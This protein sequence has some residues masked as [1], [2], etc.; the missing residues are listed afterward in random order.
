VDPVRRKNLR[1]VK[2]EGR[3]DASGNGSRLEA[4]CRRC[5]T[6]DRIVQGGA[7][8]RTVHVFRCAGAD[9]YGITQDRAGANLPVEECRA[10]WQFDKTVE[11]EGGS[12]PRDMDIAW[13]DRD[14]TVWAAVV[15]NGYFIGES[16]ALPFETDE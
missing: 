10:G 7:M 16:S 8:T 15:N 4:L 13:E 1:Q 2:E 9:L 5:V 3:F 14:A 12:S 6:L 11:L